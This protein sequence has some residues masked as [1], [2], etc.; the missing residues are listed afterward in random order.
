MSEPS[1]EPLSLDGLPERNRRGP[2]A[3]LVVGVL[4]ALSLVVLLANLATGH[5][6]AIAQLVG[7]V[8]GLL[9]LTG[10]VLAWRSTRRSLPRGLALIPG[11]GALLASRYG[12]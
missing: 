1:L 11:V 6:P 5:D 10:I 3:L 12:G 7:P 4:E 2:Q 8:H 9:W